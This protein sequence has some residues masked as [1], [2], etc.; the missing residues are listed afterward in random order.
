MAQAPVPTADVGTVKP[1]ITGFFN[2]LLEQ[3]VTISFQF[4]DNGGNAHLNLS[5]TGP[6]DPKEIV[7]DALKSLIDII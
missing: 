4:P 6:G 7:K 1:T 3:G 5:N 2:N